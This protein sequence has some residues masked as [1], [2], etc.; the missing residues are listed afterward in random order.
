MGKQ[1]CI[2]S[3][4]SLS[5]LYA[6]DFFP[7]FE[8]LFEIVFSWETHHEPYLGFP[9]LRQPHL[10]PNF[11]TESFN[12]QVYFYWVDLATSLEVDFSHDNFYPGC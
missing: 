11:K 7:I 12:L 10:V 6:S 2:F 9:R 4:L 1:G 8:I 3:L 5:F